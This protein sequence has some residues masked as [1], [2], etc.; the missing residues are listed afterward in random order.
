MNKSKA[1]FNLSPQNSRNLKRR[2]ILKMLIE[3]AGKTKAS[4]C[5]ENHIGSLGKETTGSYFSLS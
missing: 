2:K 5:F 1:F 4:V 3:K